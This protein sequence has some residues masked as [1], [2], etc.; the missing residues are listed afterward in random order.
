MRRIPCFSAGLFWLLSVGPVGAG[1]SREVVVMNLTGVINPSSA[2]Y[3]QRGIRDA[4][5]KKAQCVVLMLDTPGG[6]D[7]LHG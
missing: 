2:L 5:K 6:D 3:V 4:E 1:P 7:G